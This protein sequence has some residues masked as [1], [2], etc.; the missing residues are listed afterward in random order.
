MTSRFRIAV[1]LLATV[2]LVLP[3]ASRAQDGKT[4]AKPASA[5]KPAKPAAPADVTTQGAVTVGGQP[6]AYTAVAGTLTVGST[7]VQDAQL[8]W[9]ASRSRAASWRWPSPRSPRMQLLLRACFTWPTSRRMPRRKTGPS[10]SFITAVR[11]VPRSGCTW[12]RWAPS[13]W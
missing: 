12:V 13:T 9:M 10:P 11:A 8:G 5:E 6:I 4:A 1:G 7:D 3:L 2:L